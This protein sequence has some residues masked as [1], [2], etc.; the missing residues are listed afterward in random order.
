MEKRGKSR[1]IQG[2]ELKPASTAPSS[3]G[4]KVDGTK[5]RIWHVFPIDNSLTQRKMAAVRY[6][7]CAFP[8]RH[9]RRGRNNV[10][11]ERA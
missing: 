8:P 4:T 10:S 2:N 1:L 7:A 9:G 5:P 6:H 11:Q 3:H